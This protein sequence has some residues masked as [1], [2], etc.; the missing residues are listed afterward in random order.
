M[1]EANDRGFECI[2]LEDCTAAVTEEV[3]KAII[4]SVH[5]SN[6]IF[7]CTATALDL[8]AVL[9]KDESEVFY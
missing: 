9:P 1:R 6:G 7:G 3:K 8:L 5:M 2:L 4:D